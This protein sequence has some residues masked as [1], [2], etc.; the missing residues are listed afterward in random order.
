[1]QSLTFPAVVN[2]H[3][4]MIVI[5]CVEPRCG[6]AFELFREAIGFKR[7]R[8]DLLKKLA[9]GPVALAHPHYMPSRAKWLRKQLRFACDKFP[10]IETIFAIMHEDCKY[11]HVMPD[12]CHRLGQER[13]DLPFIGGF[14]GYHFPNQKTE[15]YYARFIKGETEITFDRVEEFKRFHHEH[16][17]KALATH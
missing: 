3:P 12:R 14:L 8:G 9:G 10:S 16:E 13:S 1:M 11:Y 5:E 2:P 7:E 6:I 17:A 15:L 4:K